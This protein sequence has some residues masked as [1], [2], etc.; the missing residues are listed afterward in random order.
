M[1]HGN[2]AIMQPYVFPYIGYFH[3]IEASSMF[4]F[5]D[6]VNY[7]KRGWIN[8]N[9]ILYNGG[10]HLFTIPVSKASQNKLICETSPAIDK[11]W[12]D[13][14]YKQITHTY[15]KAPF[16]TNV[17]ELISSLF[18]KHFA[19]IADLAIESIVSVYEYLSISVNYTRSSICSPHTKGLC[20]A[21]RLIQITKELGYRRYLNAQGGM[22]LYER[23]YFLS[24][25]V[26]LSFLKSKPISYGQYSKD[27]IP[28]LSIIDVLMFNDKE[29]TLDFLSLYYIF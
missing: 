9:R 29:R 11:R 8:R 4:I 12:K 20:K 19:N 28:W 3:L 22:S 15:R 14:F 13:K 10:A 21:D 17:F 26:I 1:K 16:F 2:V 18:E 23:D 27:F 5:Y 7:I 25:G 6:D 24:Q